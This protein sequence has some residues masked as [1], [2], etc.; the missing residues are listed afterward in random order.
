MAVSH[1]FELPGCAVALGCG[2]EVPETV[3]C[4][5]SGSSG[6]QDA[7][8]TLTRGADVPRLMFGIVEDVRSLSS[9]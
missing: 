7:T 3:S 2:V 8:V 5:D 1:D 4:H 9:Q 6:R